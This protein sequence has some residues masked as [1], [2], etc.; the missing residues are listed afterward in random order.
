MPARTS[1]CANI[2]N[3]SNIY[4]S[5][6]TYPKCLM[7]TVFPISMFPNTNECMCRWR[8]VLVLAVPV[9]R[10]QSQ[11]HRAVRDLEQHTHHQVSSHWPR[12][13]H[14]TS[15]SSLIGCCRSGTAWSR[16]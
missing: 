2:S 7:V 14:V 16:V 8:L 9:V 15:G 4:T 1:H 12:P 3:I 11:L 13:G 6:S 5:L 10:S